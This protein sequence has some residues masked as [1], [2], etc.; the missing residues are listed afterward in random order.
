[1]EIDAKDIENGEAAEKLKALG[2]L[3]DDTI[4]TIHHSHNRRSCE[5]EE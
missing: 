3:P 4:R 5:N 2:I 1:V